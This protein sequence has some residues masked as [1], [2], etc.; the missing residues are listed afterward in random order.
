MAYLPKNTVDIKES[1]GDFI[2]R[3]SGLAYMGPYIATNSGR[4]FAG[5]DTQRLGPELIK[6]QQGSIKTTNT[7]HVNKLLIIRKGLKRSVNNQ[8]DLVPSKNIPTE[9]DYKNR[10]FKR[11]FVVKNNDPTYLFEINK[12]QYDA[13]T[14]N[15]KAYDKKLYTIGALNWAL[16]GN[17]LDQ[18]FKTLEKLK[19]IGNFYGVTRLFGKLNEFEK[20]TEIQKA[21]HIKWNIKGR[22]YPNGM[23][24][25]SNLPPSYKI[26]SNSLIKKCHGCKFY[27]PHEGNTE[28]LIGKCNFW[29][30]I[31]KHQYWCKSF[32]RSGITPQ[33][34]LSYEEYQ[35]LLL[36]NEDPINAATQIKADQT[37]VGSITTESMENNGAS[38]GF[39][40]LFGAKNGKGGKSGGSAFGGSSGGSG[41]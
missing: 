6:K 41:Y 4:Y 35:Q 29:N 23:E 33:A 34:S 22:Y 7:K 12:I 38:G 19:R 40:N 2:F 10:F 21:N 9:K 36:S 39:L 8:M 24:V 37:I 16:E 13:V 1:K 30:A 25:P 31:V 28:S 20:E 3:S 15:D 14:K 26:L 32:K 17:V 18:N 27:S 5:S 11:Y